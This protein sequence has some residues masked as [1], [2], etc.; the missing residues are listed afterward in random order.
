[1]ATVNF[2]VPDGVK[3]AFNKAF[4]KLNKSAVIADLMRSAVEHQEQLEVRRESL[5]RISARRHTRRAADVQT[6]RTAREKG[7]P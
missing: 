2:S 5:R 6:L 4:A 7:R 1:M 3:K